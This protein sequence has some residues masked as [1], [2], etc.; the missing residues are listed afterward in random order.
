VSKLE[1]FGIAVGAAVVSLCVYGASFDVR[2]AWAERG[3]K[4]D[5]RWATVKLACMP[6][7]IPLSELDPFEA[8]EMALYR[9]EATKLSAMADQLDEIRRLPEATLAWKR[10][11]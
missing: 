7:Y 9:A 6:L 3:W 8:Q 2:H 5:E 1:L 4:R 11:L 10:W